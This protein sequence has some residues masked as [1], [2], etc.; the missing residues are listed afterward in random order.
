MPLHAPVAGRA[1]R[2]AFS[3]SSSWRAVDGAGD[4]EVRLVLPRTPAEL[5]H[6]GRQLHNCLADFGASVHTGASYIVGVEVYDVLRYAVEVTPSGEVRQF[7][8]ARNRAPDHA[9]AAAV[10]AHLRA[11]R[12]LRPVG[13]VS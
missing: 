11:A 3:Y 12:L 1:P 5:A 13:R 4:G 10:V 7:L 9:H 2:V 6:W 8:G